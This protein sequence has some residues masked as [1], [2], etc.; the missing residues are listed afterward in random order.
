MRTTTA[1]SNRCNPQAC[2]YR[3][4]KKLIEAGDK[5]IGT[6]DVQIDWQKSTGPPMGTNFLPLAFDIRDEQVTINALNT[7]PEG[8]AVDLLVNKCR[9]SLGIRA[10]HIKRI[11]K[12]GIR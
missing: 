5:V 10:S 9:F 12:I 6:V 7:L 3:I 2:L 8:E 1:F 11:Y 4:C